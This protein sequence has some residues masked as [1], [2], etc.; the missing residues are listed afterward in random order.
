MLRSLRAR[1]AFLFVGT[2][3]LAT[4]IAGVVLVGLYQ[5]YS[6]NQTIDTLR[7]QVQGVADYYQ[8]SWAEWLQHPNTPVVASWREFAA[9]TDAHLYYAGPQLFP[10]APSGT[11]DPNPPNGDVPM[12][13]ATNLNGPKV[14]EFK[15]SSGGDTRTYVGVAYPLRLNGTGS[16]VGVVMLAKPLTDVNNAWKNVLGSSSSARWSAWPSRSCWPRSW[17]GASPAR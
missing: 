15:P 10:N 3:L 1:L 8:R 2:L 6:K 7:T 9:Q 17:P 5:S 11:S 13:I 4:V 12:P 14:V 16:Q